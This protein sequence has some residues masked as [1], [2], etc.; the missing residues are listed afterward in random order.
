MWFEYAILMLM[1]VVAYLCG[2][3]PTGYLVGRWAGIDIRD[4]GS[5]STGATNVW[6]VLGKAQAVFVFAVD[7]M[8][9]IGA[10]VLLSSTLQFTP[11]LALWR[12][13]LVVGVS[14]MAIVGHS[15]P[16]WL[17]WRGGKSV[18]TGL[19]ILFWLS[20]QSALIALGVW[21]LVMAVSRTVSLSSILAVLSTPIVL[22]SL[23]APVVYQGFAG[24]GSLYI[25]WT[26]RSNIQRL[27]KGEEF[28]FAP[29]ESAEKV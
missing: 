4:H 16:I 9:G 24:V 18:A 27:L 2:S 3:L 23:S 7:F 28:S 12:E 20:W 10:I 8:K 14:L 1:L 5:G 26:H 13:W 25:L 17:N 6:R 22:I 15:L 29:T 11:S 19:G 21:L